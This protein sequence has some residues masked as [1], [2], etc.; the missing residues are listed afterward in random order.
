MVSYG[1]AVWRCC[2]GRVAP[3]RCGSAAVQRSSGARQC[4]RCGNYG[5]AVWRCCSRRVLLGGV[6]V[7]RFSGA[8]EPDNAPDAVVMVRRCGGAVVSG[9]LHGGVAVRWRCRGAAG[10]VAVSFCGRK[11]LGG[12][13]R[14]SSRRRFT[15]TEREPA[16]VGLFSND[17]HLFSFPLVFLFLSLSRLLFLS[18]SISF[19]L[20]SHT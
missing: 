3:W 5:A 16:V 6:A 8:A 18:D 20:G 2:G 19:F 12:D 11:I 7:R 10:C 13:H 15:F 4:A 14:L 9:W 1:A 17:C